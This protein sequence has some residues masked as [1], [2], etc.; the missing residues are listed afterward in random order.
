MAVVTD[1]QRDMLMVEC[2]FA[3]LVWT[4]PEALLPLKPLGYLTKYPSNYSPGKGS[5]TTETEDLGN[6]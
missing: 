5:V 2:V 6:A 1:R 4:C 3:N